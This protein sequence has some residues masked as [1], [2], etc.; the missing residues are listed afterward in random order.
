MALKIETTNVDATDCRIL[1]ELQEDARISMSELG[2]RVHLSQPAVKERI[3]R[4]MDVG[5]IRGF[6]ANID[7]T[8]LGYPIRAVVRITSTSSE[9]RRW[10]ELIDQM[11]EVVECYSVTGEDSFIVK[12]IAQSVEHLDK[13]IESIYDIGKPTTSIILQEID[14]PVRLVVE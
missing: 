8:K 7:M 2:R 14:R 4:L 13:I 5:I 10:L 12:V 11:D 9:D 6:H 1:L 3:R